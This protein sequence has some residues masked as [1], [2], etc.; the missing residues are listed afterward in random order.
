MSNKTPFTVCLGRFRSDCHLTQRALAQAMGITEGNISKVERGVVAPT[1]GFLNK[2][3]DALQ[4][5]KRGHWYDQFVE[6]L[7]I[8][9][10][11]LTF[12]FNKLTPKQIAVISEMNMAIGVLTDDMCDDLID[13]I[14]SFKNNKEAL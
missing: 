11:K 1:I 8:S 13:L 2:M 6:A 10:G 12:E 7:V 3:F 9:R 14:G 5:E 4:L